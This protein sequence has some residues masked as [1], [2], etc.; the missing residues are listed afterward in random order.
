MFRRIVLPVLWA[1][2]ALAGVAAAEV[3]PFGVDSAHTVVKFEVKFLG[4]VDVEGATGEERWA[5]PDGR[6]RELVAED[7]GCPTSARI[8][9]RPGVPRLEPTGQRHL[10]IA[11]VGESV[12]VIA[13]V[14]L[15]G[16][17]HLAEV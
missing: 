11:A 15:P 13:E 12:V 6:C 5:L 10:Q 17:T 8:A 14:H 1:P 3:Q 2:F 16:E 4:L 7:E 9:G